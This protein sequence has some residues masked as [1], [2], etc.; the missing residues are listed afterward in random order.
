MASEL[1]KKHLEELKS[2]KRFD[3]GFIDILTE[4]N[5]T[6]EEGAT[7]ASRILDLVK[8]RYVESKNNQA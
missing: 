2:Q 3:D 7:T 5:E 8:Q 1:I 6:S 4:A